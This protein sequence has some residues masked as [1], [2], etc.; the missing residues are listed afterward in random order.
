[1]NV[2]D[3]N[4]ARSV[5][6]VT[7]SIGPQMLAIPATQLREII[8]PLPMT[9]VPGAGAFAPWVLNVRGTVVPLADLRIPL[10]ITD[11]GP[12][13]RPEDARRF[14]VI[15]V[16]IDGDKATMAIT[17]DMVHEVVTI[18]LTRIEPVP[19]TMHWPADYQRGLFKGSDGFVLLPDLSAI[20]S[21]M[22]QRPSAA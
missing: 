7:M 11:P 19:A 4:A 8:D 16:E 12:D 20:F 14:M 6:L 9:R 15:E 17:A 3:L 13:D 1:M 21:A 5:T 22:A 18:P 10:G 2:H